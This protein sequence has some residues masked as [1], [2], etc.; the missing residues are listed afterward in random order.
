MKRHRLGA[1]IGKEKYKDK[2]T[3]EVRENSTWTVKFS[4]FGAEAGDYR[5]KRERGFETE[6]D[7]IAWWMLQKSNR[8]RPVRKDEAIKAAPLTVGEFADRWL[9]SLSNTVTVG[10]LARTRSTSDAGSSPR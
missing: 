2:K 5:C 3:G 1:W 7:A 10:A 8:R 9:K 4:P 6:D